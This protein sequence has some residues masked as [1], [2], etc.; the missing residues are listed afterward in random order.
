VRGVTDGEES[1]PT[2]GRVLISYAHDTPEHEAQVWSLCEFLREN[3]VDALIDREAA[4]SRSTG[5]TG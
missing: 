2:A 4:D 5:R 3:G 1:R